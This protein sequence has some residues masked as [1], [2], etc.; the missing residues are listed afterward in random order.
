MRFQVPAFMIGVALSSPALGH[1]GGH[2]GG[3]Y[4]RPATPTEPTVIPETL[5]G[6]VA[7]LRERV[8]AVST[9]LDASKIADLHRGCVNLVDLASAVP[10][11]SD[12]L[13]ADA[14]AKA[15]TASTHVQQK[16]AEL[17]AAASKGDT[18]AGK[19]AIAAITADVD[20]LA[21]LAK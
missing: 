2:E 4:Y 9:A 1:P 15:A 5:P 19:T 17:Y 18:A 6:V 14:K 3:G 10:T 20:L 13:S 11:K 21:G 16:V 8:T 12:A 7:A